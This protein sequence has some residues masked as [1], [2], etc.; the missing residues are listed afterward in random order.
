V[1]SVTEQNPAADRVVGLELVV[2]G[3][4]LV[5][6]REVEGV[7]LLGPVEAEQQHVAA[8]FDGHCG[9]RRHR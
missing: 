5:E 8:L 6:Q 7:A 9:L 3:G 4:E 2:R 1:I